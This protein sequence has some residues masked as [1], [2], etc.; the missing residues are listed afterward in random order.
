MKVIALLLIAG[1]VSIDKRRPCRSFK[2]KILTSSEFL[3]DLILIFELSKKWI[4]LSTMLSFYDISPILITFV[5]KQF[6]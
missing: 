4:Y 6:F 3:T 1:Y 5:V 2:N